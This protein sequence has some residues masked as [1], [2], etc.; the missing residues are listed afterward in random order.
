MARRQQETIAAKDD[1]PLVRIS[2]Q[3]IITVCAFPERCLS[4]ILVYES[5]LCGTLTVTDHGQPSIEMCRGLGPNCIFQS[6][7]IVGNREDD[8][9]F[10]SCTNVATRI[11]LQ[12]KMNRAL[13]P[14]PT[15]SPFMAV[16]RKR[17][18]ISNIL[19]RNVRPLVVLLSR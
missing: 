1:V 10:P 7:Y 19:S 12:R 15:T 6:K 14:V 13:V 3:V 8:S 9:Q 17:A 16:L 5:L 4:T 2:L 18:L 11:P